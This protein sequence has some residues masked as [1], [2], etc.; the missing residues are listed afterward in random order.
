MTRQ[1]GGYD[2]R[3]PKNLTFRRNRNAFYWRNPVTKKR[4]LSARFRDARLSP[5]RLKPTTISSKITLP[6]CSWRKSRAA[7]N[8]R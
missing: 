1:R 5:K 6:F 8:T 2:M 4:S 7:T 3:L